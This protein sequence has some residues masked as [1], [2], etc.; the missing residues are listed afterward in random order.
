MLYKEVAE[1][2]FMSNETH[3]NNEYMTSQSDCP[4]ADFSLQ[5]NGLLETCLS[6]SYAW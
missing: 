4:C 1:I 5:P 2:T 6:V 3:D